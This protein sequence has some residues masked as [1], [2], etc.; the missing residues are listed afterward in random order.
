MLKIPLH[1][2]VHLISYSTLLKMKSKFQLLT[3]YREYAH[4]SNILPKY[5]R[6]ACSSFLTLY[7]VKKKNT[8][9]KIK[10][11]YFILFIAL[12][13]RLPSLKT[14]SYKYINIEKYCFHLGVIPKFQSSLCSQMVL[15]EVNYFLIYRTGDTLQL[16]LK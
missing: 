11:N 1:C 9:C 5:S 12:L 10:R 7:K 16:L 8:D 3:I 4:S 2:P 6:I 15:T 13:W 14:S